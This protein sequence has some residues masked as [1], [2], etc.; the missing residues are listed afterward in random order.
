M[1]YMIN[2][3]LVIINKICTSFIN[4]LLKCYRKLLTESVRKVWIQKF[5][6]DTHACQLTH[7][8]IDNM[9]SILLC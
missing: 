6:Q 2:E 3:T 1:C 4:V 8:E 9:K 5:S 7:T